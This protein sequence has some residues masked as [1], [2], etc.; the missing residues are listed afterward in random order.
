VW[1]AEGACQGLAPGSWRISQAEGSH[2]DGTLESRSRG[3]HRR[4]KPR[5]LSRGVGVASGCSRECH[6]V[7]PWAKQTPGRY[8]GATLRWQDR[9]RRARLG[10]RSPSLLA[11]RAGTI[12]RRPGL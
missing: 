10:V 9:G 5:S 7:S 2:Q 4:G 12:L 11:K 1:G 3:P 8:R 6:R